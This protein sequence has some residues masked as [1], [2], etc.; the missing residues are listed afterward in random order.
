MHWSND[1]E[2]QS[3]L[4][5]STCDVNLLQSNLYSSELIEGECIVD[6]N[7]YNLLTDACDVIR[8]KIVTKTWSPKVGGPTHGPG[9]EVATAR[10]REKRWPQWRS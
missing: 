3:Q 6:H 5:S 2:Q 8:S 7:F 1:V 10:L 4:A 9:M